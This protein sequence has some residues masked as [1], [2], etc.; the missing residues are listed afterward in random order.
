[1]R[2]TFSVMLLDETTPLVV[3]CSGAY[4]DQIDRRTGA[5]RARKARECDKATSQTNKK[6]PH[7]PISSCFPMSGSSQNVSKHAVSFAYAHRHAYGQ[8][9]VPTVVPDG[10]GMAP[11][12]CA[13]NAN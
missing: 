10:P 12:F 8:A 3:C 4:P 5:R 2:T 7:L 1:M 6:S 9:V 13:K 11:K